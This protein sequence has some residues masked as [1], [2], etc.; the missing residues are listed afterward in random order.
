MRLLNRFHKNKEWCCFLTAS[1]SIINS[2]NIDISRKKEI[3]QRCGPIFCCCN[4][5]VQY[6][7]NIQT[8]LQFFWE[9]S[10][11]YNYNLPSFRLCCHYQ[12]CIQNLLKHLRWSFLLKAFD[13]F[14]KRLILDI[15]VLN[16]P[17]I[18]T[19]VIF[20]LIDCNIYL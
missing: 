13:S 6:I 18:V 4:C 10:K 19:I 17:L 8:F 11:F 9:V 5:F 15:W 12:K 1:F 3:M 14:H 7:Q 20:T 16:K 2:L